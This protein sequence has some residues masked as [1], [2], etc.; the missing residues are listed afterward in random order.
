MRGGKGLTIG[1]T[2][3]PIEHLDEIETLTQG[4]STLVVSQDGVPIEAEK[5]ATN[6]QRGG[7]SQT[8][9]C[10]RQSDHLST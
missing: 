7:L 9:V 1:A 2:L 3:P 6:F 10:E 8:I 5:K 4:A